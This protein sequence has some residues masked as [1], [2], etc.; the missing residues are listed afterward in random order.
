MGDQKKINLLKSCY[1]YRIRGSTFG[2]FSFKPSSFKHFLG[3]QWRGSSWTKWNS[4]QIHIRGMGRIC[5][6][7]IFEKD[8]SK[9]PNLHFNLHH[10]STSKISIGSVFLIFS[11]MV[12][13]LEWNY[14]RAKNQWKHNNE[15]VCGKIENIQTESFRWWQNSFLVCWKQLWNNE[16]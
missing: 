16:I 5:K 2:A 8:L 1:C 3:N 12:C 11:I 7:N 10:Q 13:I 9:I 4:W 6:I 14:T 15:P